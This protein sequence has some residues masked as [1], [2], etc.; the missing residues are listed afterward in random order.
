ML[1]GVNHIYIVI[2]RVQTEKLTK[3]NWMETWV[4]RFPYIVLSIIRYLKH[5]QA[6][7][8]RKLALI[9]SSSYYWLNTEGHK[10]RYT[11]RSAAIYFDCPAVP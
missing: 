2:F 5:I 7:V 10:E 6:E 1:R 8:F 11:H 3:E 9:P 4:Y